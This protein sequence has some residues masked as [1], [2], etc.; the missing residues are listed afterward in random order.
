MAINR[1]ANVTLDP[2]AGSLS[3]TKVDRKD[4]RNVSAPGTA[5]G[6]NLTVAWDNAVITTMTK[7]ESCVDNARL[8][9]MSQ[10]PP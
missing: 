7:W 9:A 3:G 2:S 1:W 5:D 6:G 10:L 8:I 4:H